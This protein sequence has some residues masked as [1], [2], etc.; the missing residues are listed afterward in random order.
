MVG[1]TFSGKAYLML[2][3]PSRIPDRDTNISTKSPPEQYYNSKIETVEVSEEIKLVS[4]Y[5][6]AII[7]FDNI[8]ATSN[9]RYIDQFFI[10]GRHNN[11]DIFYISQFYF[12]L[13]KRSNRNNNNKKILFNTTLKDIENKYRDTAGYDMS[14]DEFKQLCRKS[15]EEE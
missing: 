12:D 10:R 6:N 2:K 4:E 14:Y 1:P 7:V 8:S 5:E 15:W 13:P 3:H 11:S 9:S